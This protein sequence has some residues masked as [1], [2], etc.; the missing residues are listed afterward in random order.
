MPGSGPQAP[1]L[2]VRDLVVAFGGLEAL[3]PVT[4]EVARGECVVLLGP[5]GCGKSTLLSVL[6]GLLAP[7]AGTAEASGPPPG[8][9]F[10]EPT[11][12]PWADAT[13]N[14]ALP[15]VLSGV[16]EGAARLRAAEALSACGLASFE[17]ARPSALSGGMRMRCALARALVTE[18]SVLLLDEPFAAIDEPG[19]RVLDDLVRGLTVN[20][21]LAVV[22]VTHSVEEAVYLADR[23]VLLS[24]RPGRI[25]GTIPVVW[26]QPER[27][28]AF[29]TSAAFAEACAGARRGLAHRDRVSAA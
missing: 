29:L 26:D 9:V 23:V 16:A 8:M 17:H 21:G 3:G 5:S 25:A 28:T 24:A 15:L 18:P 22:F 19:R 14:V 20:R 7:S 4:L 6:A 1:A 2:S 10:Q 13:D 11:L 12:M 27:G